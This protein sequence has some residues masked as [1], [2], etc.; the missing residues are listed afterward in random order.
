MCA[1]FTGYSDAFILKTPS[2]INIQ[3]VLSA[4][5]NMIRNIQ[6]NKIPRQW[7]IKY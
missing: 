1:K 7:L 2:E 6:F 4:L 3:P 5:K